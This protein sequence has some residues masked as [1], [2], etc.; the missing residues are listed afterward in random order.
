MAAGAAI[1]F[2]VV[3]AGVI[4]FQLAL[5]LGA[6][7]GEYTLGGRFSGSLPGRM[8]V[9]AIGQAALLAALSVFVLSEANLVLPT[10]ARTLPWLIWLVV[11]FSGISLLLNTITRSVRERMIWAPVALVMLLSSLA[12]AL[13]AQ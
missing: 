6:P 2:T 4:L 12:V 8:R 10:M 11:A 3:T 13:A 9:A 1:V 5:A 7:W